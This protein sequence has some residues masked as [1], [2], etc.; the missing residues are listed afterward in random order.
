MS[1]NPFT[2]YDMY[3]IILS[4]M[5]AQLDILV[6]DNNESIRLLLKDYLTSINRNVTV[7]STGE[8]A[9]ML[10]Q[11]YKFGLIFMDNELPEHNGLQI[12]GLIW[13]KIDPG[14]PIVLF[15]ADRDGAVAKQAH[16]E[17]FEVVGKP[18]SLP[19]IEEI[20]ERKTK[21][22]NTD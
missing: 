17:G 13:N 20:V 11:K 21:E 12:A 15:I 9:I 2:I 14:V 3:V 18:F 5:P 10:V 22:A 1:C 8:E 4:S 7:A 19:E 6:V 16:N